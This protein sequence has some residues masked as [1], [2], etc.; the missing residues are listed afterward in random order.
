MP[1]LGQEPSVMGLA[2]DQGL[3]LKAAAA[4]AVATLGLWLGNSS[5]H[6]EKVAAAAAV[7]VIE[8]RLGVGDVEGDGIRL[9]PV[10]ERHHHHAGRVGLQEEPA[11]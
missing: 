2:V 10:E 3:G 1:G 6:D 11:P 7:E 9:G 4:A 8:I 5:V